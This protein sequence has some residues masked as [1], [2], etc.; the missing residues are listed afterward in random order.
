MDKDQSL[1]QTSNTSQRPRTR[2]LNMVQVI[3]KGKNTT[4]LHSKDCSTLM[5]NLEGEEK[6]KQ[7]GSLPNQKGEKI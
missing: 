2:K 1:E 5:R 3:K 7:Q 4:I 6:Q